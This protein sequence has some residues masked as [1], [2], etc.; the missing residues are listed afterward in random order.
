MINGHT[1]GLALSCAERY[2]ASRFPG[3]ILANAMNKLASNEDYFRESFQRLDLRSGNLENAR[4][5]ECE[6]SHCDFTSTRFSRCKFTDCRFTHCNLS[7]VEMSA[8]RLY[9]LSFEECKLSG[10]DWTGASWPEYNLEADLHF[11]KS[12]L[13][14]GSFFGLALRG[15][16]MDQCLLQGVDFRECDLSNA[17]M[18]GCD[19]TGSLFNKT[20]LRG[21]DLTDSW[22]FTIDVMNNTLSGAKFSRYEALALLESL[23]IE[24]VD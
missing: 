4:F 15:L 17:E 23:G 13:T 16:K 20:T 7:L 19:L 22:N 5:E 11:S 14:S 9:A 2:I 8:A 12:I 21:A 18:V 3:Q 10:I 6:F 1:F 24:L